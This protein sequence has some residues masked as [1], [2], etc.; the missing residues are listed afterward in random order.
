MSRYS[1]IQR[2]MWGDERFRSLSAPP[3]NAQTL[4]QFLLTGQHNTSLPGLFRLRLSAVSEEL[5]WD[6]E[7][8]CKVFDEITGAGMAQYDKRAGVMWIPKALRHNAPQ[9]P[10]VVAG[11]RDEITLIPE[12]ALKREAVAA[13]RG[14]IDALGESFRVAMAR[15]LGEAP[16]MKSPNPSGKGRPK[17]LVPSDQSTH[18]EPKALQEPTKAFGENRPIQEQEQEQEQ[19]KDTP[20]PPAG[21]VRCATEEPVGLDAEQAM[22]TVRERAGRKK[23]NLAHD[24]NSLLAWSKAV[25]RVATEGEFVALVAYQHLGDWIAAGG[26]NW[27]SQGKPSLAYLLRSGVLAKHLEDAAEWDRAS[28]PPIVHQ[29]AS[30]TPPRASSAA[31]ASR[32]RRLGPAPCSTPAEFDADASAPDPLFALLE[33]TPS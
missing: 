10:N 6:F 32:P 1:K 31:P 24:A 29:N 27:W 33:G 3:P 20:L 7:A 23:I 18:L 12:C 5:G 9:S 8:T 2:S 16:P 13:T 14:F 21:G 19:Q 17:A 22:L 4:W 15:A 11:W 26:L 28:R 30:Q 25:E